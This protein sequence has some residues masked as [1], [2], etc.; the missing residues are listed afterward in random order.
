ME[1]FLQ[2]KNQVSKYGNTLQKQL[3][4]WCASVCV[5]GENLPRSKRYSWLATSLVNASSASVLLAAALQSSTK[6]FMAGDCSFTV[7][8]KQHCSLTQHPSG[9]AGAKSKKS[10]AS[11]RGLCR[12]KPSPG[13][14]E[15]GRKLGMNRVPPHVFPWPPLTLKSSRRVSASSTPPKAAVDTLGHNR[16][17]PESSLKLQ[18]LFL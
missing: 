5:S 12:Q 16:S 18:S 6:H 15:G 11:Y 1:D 17:P 13:L 8:S 14:K 2:K 3:P 10:S 7:C 9:N 4:C